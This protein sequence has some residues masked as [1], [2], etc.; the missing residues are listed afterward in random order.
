LFLSRDA[1]LD[2]SKA[3]RGGVPLVFPQFGQPDKSM[4]QHGFLRVTFW[5]VDKSSIYDLPD[6]AGVTYMLDLKDVKNARGGAWDVETTKYDCK[7]FYHIKIDGKSFTTELEIQNTGTVEFPFQTLLHT[8]YV[9]D[10]KA[11]LDSKQCNVTGLAGYSVDDKISKTTY[12][13]EESKDPII[14]DGE[15]DRVYNPPP[16]STQTSNYKNNGVNVIVAVGGG[17]TMKVSATGE[18]D[19]ESVAVSCVVWNPHIEKAEGMSD[20]TN[21]Q[22]H[23][24]ICVEPGL[25]AGETLRPGKKAA[26]TVTSELVQKLP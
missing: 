12:I 23:E 4:P 6:S 18:V 16:P 5:T 3:I 26:L 10:D 19:G 8:Y 21:D 1:K 13:H 9:V 15:I 25:L 7:L 24:M 20:F 2:G 22:Y 17:N 14:I 11:A